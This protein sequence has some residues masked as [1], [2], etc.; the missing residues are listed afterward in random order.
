MS[1]EPTHYPSPPRLL[2]GVSLM[3][4]G[5]LT[6]H[7]LFAITAALL[8]EGCHWLNWRWHFDLRGYSRAWIL[9]LMALAGTVGFH[10]LNLSGPAALLA[11]IEWLPMIFLPLMLAQQYGEASAVPTSVFSLIARQ[12]LKRERRL[13]K[14][15][16]DTRIQLGYPYFAITLL[17]TAYSSPGMKQQWQYFAIMV[18]LTG[19]AFYFANRSKQRRVLPWVVMVV[20]ISLSSMASSR[21]LVRLSAWVQNGGFLSSEGSEPPVEQITAIGRLGSLKLSRSI[22]WRLTVPDNKPAPERVM[23]LAYNHFVSN[24]WQPFDPDFQDYDRS[25]S[26]LLTIAGKKNEGEFAFD[27]NGFEANNNPDSSSY[28]IYLRGAINSNLKPIPVPHSPSLFAKATEVDN[29]EQSKLGTIRVVNA[30]SV[31]DLEIWP[32]ND[33]SLREADPTQRIRQSLNPQG[34]NLH[35]TTSL[36][37]PRNHYLSRRLLSI[38]QE[39]GLHDISDQD[40]IAQLRFHFQNNFRYTTHLKIADQK[41]NPALL[42]FLTSHKEGH[43]EYFASATTLLLRAAGVP[44][45]YVVGF[46]VREKSGRPG[47]YLLRGTH[48]HAWTR[49]YLG[50]TKTIEDQQ[51]TITLKDGSEKTITIQRE[52]WSGGEWTDVD[53]TPATWLAMDSPEPDFQERFADGLQRIRE[54]FQ[55]WRANERNRGWVNLSLALIAIAV[56]IFVVVR[57]KGSRV[58]KEKVHPQSLFVP[59]ASSTILSEL[60]PKLEQTIGQKPPGEIL[61]AW[62]Q[63][64]LP[65]FP[66]ESY[67]QL[68]D[69]HDHQRFSSRSLR[70]H[71]IQEFEALVQSLARTC[72][73]RKDR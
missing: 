43:C 61:S 11:F 31:V 30:D 70:P 71:Q 20:L 68:F 21:G 56:L 59:E 38:A 49:A 23:S 26:D 48:A 2:L 60:L 18:A 72:T 32:G 4:W 27:T 15:I 6:H 25:Y 42:Q 13:G 46:A 9:S 16:P 37:L 7:G 14:V 33:S 12:R 40:K 19:V 57:L 54:D 64:N 47:E 36:S 5:A 50:G 51:Q 3:V 41:N 1:Q 73:Q 55:L 35:E 39:L 63:K 22:E 24:K 67:H 17:A 58:Q 69:F 34:Y 29:I 53:L 28:P 52:V 66:P 10:S 44:A 65:D 8:V 45:H 62:L